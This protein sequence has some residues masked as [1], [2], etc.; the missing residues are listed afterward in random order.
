MLSAAVF[1]A[2]AIAAT[3]IVRASGRQII[4]TER[5]QEYAESMRSD[6]V[7]YRDFDFEYPPGALGVFVFPAL[8]VSGTSEYFWAFGALMAVA[9]GVGVLLTAAA[10]GRL[11]RPARVKRWVLALLALSPVA[12][13]GVLLTRFDLV[14][15]ALVAGATLLFL[16]DRP[17]SASLTLGVA[18]AVKLYPLAVLP[19]L[20][21][22]TWRRTDRREAVVCSA[23]AV[24]VVA[25]AYLPFVLLAP[26]SVASS[27][28]QQ[29]SRPLQ[30]ESLG[31]GVL[32]LLHHA[33]GLD[34]VVETTYGS[35]NL[36][37]ATAAGVAV[38]LSAASI[39]VLCWLWFRFARGEMTHERLV[40]YGAATLVAVVVFGKMLS[41]QFLVWLLFPLAL[42]AGRR[43]AAA[44]ACF[45]VAAIATA[46]WFPWLYF[47]LP[48]D[49][50]PFVATLV[51]VRGVA[52]I[53]ALAILAWPRAATAPS[54]SL[55]PR[56]GAGG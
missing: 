18:A 48:R 3:G 55:R 41:P 10:L 23:L 34:V 15:A 24:G 20:A 9:G 28:W 31:A 37:G 36:T 39:V 14:P 2:V 26:S 45:A 53:A 43:G 35:Q 12:L 32:L 7:P 46:V 25:L 5:Y 52:L 49:R 8:V 21:I 1:V 11:E 44:G 30:I 47:E 19:L 51:V 27:V 56:A 42:V 54:S 17:R 50:D 22:W 33:T 13:G 16:S 38:A 4:D 6:L 29:V 40:R